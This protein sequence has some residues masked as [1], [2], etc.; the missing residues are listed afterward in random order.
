MQAEADPGPKRC[1]LHYL[2]IIDACL[3]IVNNCC[4]GA[5]SLS[6]SLKKEEE[7]SN[8]KNR[9]TEKVLTFDQRPEG[10]FFPVWNF[11][12][13]LI[14]LLLLEDMVG[15]FYVQVREGEGRRGRVS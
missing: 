6:L 11:S 12:I 2:H 10:F 9:N 1:R 14:N 8:S 4:G 5:V 15:R 3:Y 13:N 7:I